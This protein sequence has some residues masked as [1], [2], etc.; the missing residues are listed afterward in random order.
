[1]RKRRGNKQKMGLLTKIKKYKWMGKVF[2][3]TG[4]KNLKKTIQGFRTEKKYYKV[5]EGH[6]THVNMK[7]L[8]QCSLCPNMCR[9]ECPSLR[10]TQK[11]MY[12][13]ATKAR[14]MYHAERGDLDW[15][16][17]HTAEV[18]YMCTNC[19]GCRNWCPMDISTGELLS[20]VR[21]DLVDQHIHFPGTNEF[22]MRVVKNQTA[23]VPETFSR[24][25]DLNVNM[26]D[27]EV[28]Y[29]TGCVMA[30]K[31]PES[32]KAN[33]K[34]LEKAGIKF[35]THMD[36]RTCCGGPLNT[37]GFLDSVKMFAQKNIELFENS[38]AKIIV[39][40][41]PAC[42]HTIRNSYKA[43][44][45]DHQFEVYTSVEFYRK[46]I[47]D[48]RITPRLP[49]KK[50]ITYH[51][52]CIS[53]RGKMGTIDIENARFIFSKI[54]ELDFREVYLHGAETQCCGRGGVQRIHHPEIADRIGK[55]RVAELRSTG[56]E[57]IVSACP[58][59]E[60]GF[61]FNDGNP[62]LDIGE[63]LADSLED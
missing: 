38:G 48:G 8:A 25:E 61:M 59:C 3:R 14:L 16:D 5:K 46:L 47:E 22:N 55:E 60:E 27:P 63:I 6:T 45:H 33:M 21:A 49:V 56:A 39:A 37:L 10:V 44:G 13:P 52:P 11:E 23:F 41:C 31:K 24:H 7:E 58:A 42:T 40:D 54:P 32:V 30:E 53:S 28:F 36:E 4:W 51:D 18:A 62:V 20:Q 9:F 12:A 50:S 29:Y 17:L 34:I 2:L 15:H 43:V 19:D 1:M 35:C 57:Y 26:E